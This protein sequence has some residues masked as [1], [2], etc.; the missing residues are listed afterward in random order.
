MGKTIHANDLSVTTS[1]QFSLF[2]SALL[3][4]RIYII[5]SNPITKYPSFVPEGNIHLIVVVTKP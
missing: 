4:K 2:L 5:T 3:V 1:N